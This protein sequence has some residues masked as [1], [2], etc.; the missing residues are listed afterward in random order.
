LTIDTVKPTVTKKDSPR[1]PSKSLSLTYILRF[2]ETVTGLE[3]NDFFI[4][5]G[6]CQ[7]DSITTDSGS[8][9][10]LL[11]NCVDSKPI[12]LM[13]QA[14][15]VTDSLGNVGPSQNETFSTVLT[16]T[17]Y[18][19]PVYAA[20]KTAPATEIQKNAEAV[21]P[22]RKIETLKQNEKTIQL[23][24]SQ[25]VQIEKFEATEIKATR[26][27]I[28]AEKHQEMVT[29]VIPATI[30]RQF[31]ALMSIE[32]DVEGTPKVVVYMTKTQL[33]NPYFLM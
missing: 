28:T 9:L 24:V 10:V 26:I 30:E 17:T 6:F 31:F 29:E 20:P 21:I 33:L 25:Q 23:T 32:V 22:S 11:N 5:G 18:V 16:D 4:S 27:I 3:V 19:E 15:S 14:D 13:L 1:S 12:S 2:S 7:V 8:Y